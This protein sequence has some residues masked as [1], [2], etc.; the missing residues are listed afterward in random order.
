MSRIEQAL[1]K[2]AR[3]REHKPEI[4]PPPLMDAGVVPLADVGVAP[5]ADAGL[6]RKERDAA[7]L[8]RNPLPVNSPFLV[9]PGSK[10]NPSAGE[11]YRK[12]KSMV[13]R[14]TK[15]ERFLNTLL[16]TSAGSNEGKTLTAL[17]LAIV[18]AQDYEHSVVLVDADLRKP[19]VHRYLEIHPDAGLA[20]CLQDNV[21]I[22]RVLVKTGLGRLVVLPAGKSVD[23]PVEL[24]ASSRMKEIVRELKNRY[25]DRFVIFD[26]PPAA[27]FADAHVLGQEVDGVLFVVREGVAKANDVREGLGSL[28]D[29]N[30]LG[31]VYNDASYNPGSGRYYYY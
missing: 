29:A 15:R 24:L 30:L 16:I 20:Q 31:V 12:L 21:P 6:E 25:P 27:P 2:A 26:T 13:L 11:E 7:L 3:Q 1:E 14:L 17:N 4:I 10:S 23:D 5:L 22:S 9:I 19:S 18:L 28:R 8:L